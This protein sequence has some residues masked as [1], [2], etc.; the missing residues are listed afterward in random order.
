VYGNFY[1]HYYGNVDACTCSGYQAFFPLPL[2]R[3]GDETKY[4]WEWEHLEA[5][6]TKG[7]GRVQDLK[8]G[9]AESN[10]RALCKIFATPL[11]NVFVKDKEDRFRPSIDEKL[12][13]LQW[14]VSLSPR[15]SWLETPLE[16]V[17][18]A[19]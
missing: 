14:P 9:G 3:P 2:R 7:Q 4:T 12:S 15:S 19:S 18:H 13:E 17:G 8:K 10:A 11:I 1:G 6:A 16:E 5:G